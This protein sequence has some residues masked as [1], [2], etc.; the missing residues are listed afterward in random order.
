MPGTHADDLCRSATCH[1]QVRTG[2]FIKV[3][4]RIAQ[5]SQRNC[6][7]YYCG[8][9][10]KGQPTGKKCLRGLAESLNYLT[11]GMKDKA[12]G[13]QWHRITHRVLTDL[14]HRVTR[15]TAPEE[16]NLAANSHAHDPTAAEFV[17]TYRSADF[18]GGQL[19]RRLEFEMTHAAAREV[20]KSLPVPSDK[21]AEQ[22]LQHFDDLYG[23]RGQHESVFWLSPWEFLAL[24]EVVP[25][26]GNVEI[27][28]DAVDKVA[29]PAVPGDVQLCDKFYMR[30][31]AKPVVPAPSHTRL[32]YQ[33]TT[34]ED[35]ARLY[36]VYMRPWVLNPRDATIEVPLLA[37][38]CHIPGSRA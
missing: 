16:W 12:P 8:Y 10:F 29:Y 37:N 21:G 11:A 23:Y 13:Q 17:R 6:T 20:L 5:R 22:W 3:A 28:N 31:R 26:K 38:L 27:A 15:R 1:A 14:Q 36:S 18:K 32:P 34:Q 19:L 7:A 35:K 2:Q 33:E 24:W 30:R 25:Y 9:T 4:S